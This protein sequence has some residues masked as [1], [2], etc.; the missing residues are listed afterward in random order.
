MLFKLDI[1]DKSYTQCKDISQFDSR[2]ITIELFQN[3][4]P[5]SIATKTIK[6][7]AKN[8]NNNAIIQTDGITKSNNV[9]TV[10]LKE[11]ITRVSG[12]VEMK[13]ILTE[14]SKSIS[15]FKFMLNVDSSVTST[16]NILPAIT[17]D[18]IEILQ[19][20][21][22][23]AVKVKDDTVQAIEDNKVAMEK[24]I[25]D[26][27]VS[28]D[29]VI[30][31]NVITINKITEDNKQLIAQNKVAVKQD[32]AEINS[33]LD[34]T[35]QQV[36]EVNTNKVDKVN[37]KGLTTND[38]DNTEKSEVAKV[39]N[40]ADVSYVD[41]R[42]ASI[43]SGTPLFATNVSGMTD[44]TKNYVNTTDGFLYTYNGTSFVKSSLQYQSTGLSEGSLA[45]KHN[46][47]KASALLG[48][49]NKQCDWVLGEMQ[50]GNINPLAKNQVTS[51]NLIV[52]DDNISLNLKDTTNLKYL[53]YKYTNTGVY[54]GAWYEIT[55]DTIIEKDTS[56]GIKIGIKYKD[57]RLMS[58]TTIS[59]YIDVFVDRYTPKSLDYRLKSIENHSSTD[60]IPSYWNT[61]LDSK[62]NTI[63]ALQK[64]IGYNGTSFAMITDIHWNDNAQNSPKILEK[65]MNEC[66]VNYYFDGGDFC[67][68]PSGLTEAQQ[69]AE[70]KSYNSAFSNIKGRRLLAKGNHDDNS[71]N[72]KF[73][74]TITDLEMYDLLYRSNSLNNNFKKGRTGDY[75]YIDDEMTKIR[76][77]VLNCID[78][79][80]IQ[81]GD[82]LKYKGM[83]TWVF[84]QEQ[85]TW[86]TNVALNVPS[87]DYGVVVCSHI[88]INQGL[89]KNDYLLMNSLQAFNDKSTYQGS[90][91][92][93]TDFEASV[94]VNYTGKGGVAICW[95]CGHNHQDKYITLPSNIT[96]KMVCCLNDSL[97]VVSGQAT[98]TRGTDTEQAFDIFTI[99]KLTRTVNITRIGA[100]ADRSFTY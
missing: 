70:I 12:K 43:S 55:S 65:V 17:V 35:I 82:G 78:I 100:G 48:Y 63:N 39:K 37:G 40:K 34:S 81:S 6:L 10:N 38:Y 62:I 83:D 29:K 85:I 91:N 74:D 28:N 25:E 30:A 93:G 96:F 54:T 14:N 19:N 76:Y 11:D 27:K 97:Q 36:N 56:R 60:G 87:N 89:I 23:E 41:T 52:L 77:I 84:R 45:I 49:E 15:T 7:E 9:I 75:Y 13:I 21:I 94:N 88:P 66:N 46:D 8:S 5:Y 33:Q 86:F 95:I 80:Y 99:N 68:N 61:Q 50:S 98:K 72:N 24:M 58:D 22:D 18:V 73:A 32:I 53:I 3:G 31:D 92:I 51:N 2:T 90:A 42:V 64:Q 20:K 79:P 71:I 26:N 16:A 59:K 47:S 44:T 1:N 67:A 4:Q 57:N 69:V